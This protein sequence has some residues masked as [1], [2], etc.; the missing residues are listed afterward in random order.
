MASPRPVTAG[1]QP[2][3]SPM[4]AMK[5]PASAHSHNLST[6]SQPSNTP[7]LA[8]TFT[9]GAINLH[10]P[11]AFIGFS[12]SQGLTPTPSGLE[13]LGLQSHPA[14]QAALPRNTEVDKMQRLQDVASLLKTRIAGRG[15]TREGVVRVAQLSGFTT[16]WDEDLLTV[17]GNCVDLEIMFDGG[18]KDTVKDVVLKISASGSEKRQEEASEILKRDLAQ[19]PDSASQDPWNML[20][21]F[22]ENIR[23]LR[24]LDRLSDTVNCFEAVDGIYDAFKQVWEQEKKR[25]TWRSELH[26]IC[27]GSAGRSRMNKRQKLGVAVEY[28]VPRHELAQERG[29]GDN[30]TAIG[31]ENSGESLDM[32]W[33]A[34]ISC[35]AG[36]PSLRVSREWLAPEILT[37]DH[38][39]DLQAN[40]S[41]CLRPAWK[42]HDLSDGAAS[43]DEN[44]IMKVDGESVLIADNAHFTFTLEPQVYLP[45]GVVDSL[46]GQGLMLIADRSKVRH[47]KQVLEG[48]D[49]H[50]WLKSIDTYDANGVK[51]SSKVSYELSASNLECYPVSTVGFAHPSQLSSLLPVFR[52]YACLWSMLQKLVADSVTVDEAA[53]CEDLLYK[54]GGKI[55][56]K[57]VQ[58]RSNIKSP[59]PK[60]EIPTDGVDSLKVDITLS[61][62]EHPPLL[63]PRLEVYAPFR[64]SH[65]P[66]AR[67]GPFCY[68]AFEI[69]ENGE[70]KML[71]AQIPGM[72]GEIA[73]QLAGRVISLSED[74]GVLVEWMLSQ[75]SG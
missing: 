36:F 32:C 12:H 22:A 58:K 70:L 74:I 53:Q 60:K 24:Q 64:S 48:T 21:A 28:W 54:P 15:V 38:S 45:L 63:K 20:D 49:S 44:D 18:H 46:V 50:R 5:T 7:L 6:S 31:L 55:K 68:A 29:H 2:Y 69:S 75:A 47:Y 51:K 71:A 1:K 37:S 42:I 17:A 65:K 41:L 57:T 66:A 59:M 26:H 56:V 43:K 10:S 52:Q 27:R 30:E 3:K 35:E 61:F 73:K 13:G 34:Q 72:D 62:P 23:R 11:S 16:Y 14:T 8:H 39:E 4:A 33:A 40:H 9:D 67:Q 25:L 19:R